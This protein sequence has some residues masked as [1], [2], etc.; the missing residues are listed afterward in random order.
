VGSQAALSRRA[1]ITDSPDLIERGKND[2]R[3][4]GERQSI[5]TRHSAQTGVR[6]WMQDSRR[7][8]AGFSTGM[9][10]CPES[11]CRRSWW[12]AFTFSPVTWS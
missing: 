12:C 3:P 8:R 9:G 7:R 11:A 5:L 1:T 6:S 2:Y 10:W 4:Y